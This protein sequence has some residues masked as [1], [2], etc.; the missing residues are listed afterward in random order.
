MNT[1]AA[2]RELRDFRSPRVIRAQ[3]NVVRL[4]HAREGRIRTWQDARRRIPTARG[5][6]R[7]LASSI[8]RINSYQWHE[9]DKAR[10]TGVR[11]GVIAR[12]KRN[13]DAS[14]QRRVDE[15]ERL[16]SCLETSLK[17]L[18]LLGDPRLPLSSETPGSIADRISILILKIY[19]MS[20][21]RRRKDAT[22][23]QRRRFSG[24]VRILKEQLADLSSCLDA[25]MEDILGKSRRFKTYFQL[26]MYNDPETNPYMRT[27]RRGQGSR[28]PTAHR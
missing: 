9:E 24:K 12:I 11:D 3:S 21:Q 27:A 16:D 26:K 15:I 4:W 8:A 20:E 10:A 6:L 2:K 13:I 14:N 23:A 17:E 5:R 1:P 18:G 22:A 28:K 7:E 19:H 25:L